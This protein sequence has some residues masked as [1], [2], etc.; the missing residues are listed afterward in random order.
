[1]DVIIPHEISNSNYWS[2]TN[3]GG[4]FQNAYGGRESRND[5]YLAPLF[6]RFKGA[7]LLLKSQELNSTDYW[8]TLNVTVTAGHNSFDGSTNA[9]E[10]D[11]SNGA[12]TA[13][14]FTDVVIDKTESTQTFSV[15][16]NAGTAE[17]CALGVIFQFS[18]A[19]DSYYL[20]FNPVAGTVTST[21]A[22]ATGGIESEAGL[23]AGW[24]RAW[25]TAPHNNHVSCK[26]AIYPA[27]LSVSATG[28]AFFDGAQYNIGALAGYLQATTSPVLSNEFGFLNGTHT[29]PAGENLFLW[30]EDMT[31]AAWIKTGTGTTT[32]VGTDSPSLEDYNAVVDSDTVANQ[33]ALRQDATIANDSETYTFSFFVRGVT[34]GRTEIVVQTTGVSAITASATVDFKTGRIN[35]VSSDG[36]EMERWGN[37]WW[38][39][40][41]SIT[42]NSSGNT[43]GRVYLRPFDL[44]GG[45]G[46]IHFDGAQFE[47][48]STMTS[49]MKS[50]GTTGTRSG[51]TLGE[52]G[53]RRLP[54]Y[55]YNNIPD[56]DY[57]EWLAGAFNLGDYTQKNGL[58][59]KCSADPTTTDDPEVGV[60]L[61]PPTWINYGDTNFNRLTNYDSGANTYSEVSM[62]E[63]NA[64]P[65][66]HIALTAGN[67][68]WGRPY[69]SVAL[70]GMFGE[71]LF[72][73]DEDGNTTEEDIT[74]ETGVSKYIKTDRSKESVMY[75]TISGADANPNY[76]SGDQNKARIGKLLVGMKHNI[77]VTTDMPQV[78]LVDLSTTQRDLAG[79]VQRIAGEQY[80]I[81]DYK[82][83]INTTEN[84]SQLDFVSNL[85]ATTKIGKVFSGVEDRPETLTYGFNTGF[86]LN[87]SVASKSPSDLQVTGL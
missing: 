25:I 80:V 22:G 7:N 34:I 40:S 38:R 54:T 61:D 86:K 42:N 82:V 60:A 64:A 47:K 11:D 50:E 78:R 6:N 26:C 5:D 4:T 79:N 37:D 24:F 74:L 33:Y 52:S 73:T 23:P 3:T 35:S 49:Y 48:S 81:A 69:D 45:T 84:Q 19:S 85:R 16:F 12:S 58:I 87:S 39:V 36:F 62:T 14:L 32:L 31:N 59:Y 44:A 1:M 41:I 66:I 30:S 67:E 68:T 75:I 55:L 83:Q 28:T 71:K 76:W 77:G 27:G 65:L 43:I 20:V 10:I 15:Y 17:E 18:G 72:I 51:T 70:F 63:H 46:T 29:D 21:T 53:A 56:R 9:V 13:Q 57:D 8:E 2:P